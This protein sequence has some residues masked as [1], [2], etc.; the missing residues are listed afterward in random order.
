M[1]LFNC[2]KNC[3]AFVKPTCLKK[4]KKV[5]GGKKNGAAASAAAA[6]QS[7]TPA[8]GAA[9]QMPQIRVCLAGNSKK[10]PDNK[11]KEPEQMS[12]NVFLETQSEEALPVSP[13]PQKWRTSENG[14]IELNTLSPEYQNVTAMLLEDDSIKSP[15]QDLLNTP[16]ATLQPNHNSTRIVV[17]NNP[18]RQAIDN[19]KSPTADFINEAGANKAPGKA[20]TPENCP[21]TPII[22][23]KAPRK[24]F[25]PSRLGTPKNVGVSRLDQEKRVRKT[26]NLVNDPMKGLL[27]VPRFGEMKI[28]E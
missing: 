27:D 24:P 4:I 11:P 17:G 9:P 18:T 10:K 26:S 12:D 6:P 5:A 15:G 13:N 22:M 7:K 28:G 14:V 1:G 16:A 23:P 20:G 19:C 21:R 8:A 25:T 3:G 2:K